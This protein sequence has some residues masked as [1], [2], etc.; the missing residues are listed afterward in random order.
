M[1][2][3]DYLNKL[4]KETKTTNL[5]LS[6]WLSANGKEIGQNAI[7]K[8]R[9]NNRVPNIETMKLIASY[10]NVPEQYFFDGK[11]LP[12]FSIP[13]IGTAS[14]GGLDENHLQIENRVAYYNGDNFNS[15][16]YCV[17]ANGD[18]M[19]PEIEDGDEIICDPFIEP[20][21][22]DIV[23]YRIGNESAIKI[24]FKD[25]DAFIVQ[26]IPYNQN[27]DFKTK[28]IRLDDDISDELKI[29][30]VVSVNKL[31]FNNRK[32]RLKLIGRA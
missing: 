13:I 19:A 2:Y 28:T 30:K 17:I 11:E 1:E 9:N 12:V 21:N 24:Y 31:K 10:F 23:H 14:C 18:S 20:Q 22:G 15:N 5:K 8:Y 4:M 7:A 29:A 27:E 16:L 32:S 6:D 25:E 3:G 26:F